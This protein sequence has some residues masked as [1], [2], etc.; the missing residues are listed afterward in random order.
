MS[1]SLIIWRISDDKRGFSVI[2]LTVKSG[3]R[4]IRAVYNEFRDEI[5][6]LFISRSEHS[7]YI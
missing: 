5:K 3:N 2:H 6:M 1:P 4:L 7:V